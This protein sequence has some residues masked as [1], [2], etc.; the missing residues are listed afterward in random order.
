MSRPLDELYFDWLYDQVGA[1]SDTRSRKTYKKLLT[2]LFFKEFVW[3]VPNDD[4]RA[5]DGKDLRREFLEGRGIR[6]VNDDWIVIGC[7][8]L[9]LF[10]GLSRRLSFEA[11]GDPR[12]WF[13]KLIQNAKLQRFSDNSRY[14]KNSVDEILDR[15]IWRTYN[16][17]GQG[18]LFPLTRAHEDQRD[19]ELWYQLSAYLLEFID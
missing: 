9:E 7:S 17:D 11:D 14:S 6:D 2:Q 10:I 3:I 15:L 16:S 5:E 13:W 1:D 18:G 19:V 12:D 4:N 8:M